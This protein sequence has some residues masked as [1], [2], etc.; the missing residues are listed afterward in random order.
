VQSLMERLRCFW[1]YRGHAAAAAPGPQR[2]GSAHVQPHRAAAVRA[3]MATAAAAA[4]AAAV[5]RVR[6]L[7]RTQPMR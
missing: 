2:V 3:A 4:S 5:P 6:A 7:P 1:Q